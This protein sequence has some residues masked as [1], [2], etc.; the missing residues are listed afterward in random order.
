[1]SL[2]GWMLAL[3]LEENPQATFCSFSPG[4][5]YVKGIYPLFQRLQLSVAKLAHMFKGGS[6]HVF[7]LIFSS[8]EHTNSKKG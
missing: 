4:A 1:M 6:A 7:A 8:P 5:N 2:S 3:F